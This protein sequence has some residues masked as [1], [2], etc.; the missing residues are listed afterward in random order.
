MPM[1]LMREALSRSF[2]MPVALRRVRVRVVV[3]LMGDE[4]MNEILEG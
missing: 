1:D 3:K 4:V 2:M